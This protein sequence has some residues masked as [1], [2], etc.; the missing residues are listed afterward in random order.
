MVF[1]KQL[2]TTTWKIVWS[3]HIKESKEINEIQKAHLPFALPIYS[4]TVLNI[5]GHGS[6]EA[7]M[8]IME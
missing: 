4:T 1:L 2:K 3:K 5:D 8:C 6:Q 7:L